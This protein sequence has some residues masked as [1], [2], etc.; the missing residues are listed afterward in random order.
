MKKFAAY[1]EAIDH[2]NRLGDGDPVQWLFYPGMLFSSW[3]KWWGDFG[4]RAT[5]HE[6]I[7]ITYYRTL[8]GNL[9]RFDPSI[10][11]PAMEDGLIINI[12]DDFLGRTLII[13]HDQ[14]EL[15]GFNRHTK[16]VSAYAHLVPEKGLSIGQ[17]IKKDQVLARVC[18]NVKNPQLPPHFHFSCFEI[19]NGLAPEKLDWPL[20]S[21]RDAAIRLIHPLFL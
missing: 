13:E 20:F 10:L 3:D 8:S 2:L 21:S 16:I 11:I 15:S 17:K 6:G 1:L 4:I 5:A 19:F 18:P 9:C 12:C 14:A 7:D